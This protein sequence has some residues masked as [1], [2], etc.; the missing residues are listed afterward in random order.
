MKVL[1]VL[2]IFIFSLLFKTGNSQDIITTLPSA[3]KSGN[4]NVI[5]KNFDKRIDITIDEN[6]DNYSS[7]QAE[8]IL[9]NFLNKFSS[10]QFQIIHQGTSSGAAQYAIGNLK[11]NLGAYRT[12]VYIRKVNNIQY[13]QEIRFEKE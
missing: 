7:T 9:K 2:L 1:R 11:T 13:I 12:Y 5:A 6:A 10:R 8:V 4:A 3:L